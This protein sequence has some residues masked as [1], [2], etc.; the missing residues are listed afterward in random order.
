[1][2]TVARWVRRMLVILFLAVP[3]LASAAYV[4]PDSVGL[5]RRDSCLTIWRPVEGRAFCFQTDGEIYVWRGTAWER[6]SSPV[7]RGHISGLTI[8]NSGSSITVA[9]GE[10]S[11]DNPVTVIQRRMVLSASI[12]KNV[13]AG[14]SLG[15]GNGCFDLG[16]PVDGTIHA[17]LV[18]NPSY[19]FVDVL[20]SQSPT[21]PYMAIGPGWTNS[22]RIG[23]FLRIGGLYPQFVQDGD[24]FQWKTSVLDVNAATNPGTSAVTRTLTVPTGLPLEAIVRVGVEIGPGDVY[25]GALLSDLAVNDEAADLNSNAQVAAYVP[26]ANAGINVVEAR[27]RT[28]SSA[29]IRSRLV[30]STATTKLYIR[31]VGWIDRRGRD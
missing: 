27:V 3:S 12:T 13:A 18:E 5:F 23:S 25:T 2:P 20:C 9:P 24:S 11:S 1:M 30:T 19:G 8:T 7:L 6:I 31:T 15:T 16:S 21:A 10:A 4:P 17:F 14:F 22:R 26:I 29:Q 28:N